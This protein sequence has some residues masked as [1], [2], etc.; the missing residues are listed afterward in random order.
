MRALV[1]V[2][3]AALGIVFPAVSQFKRIDA[4]PIVLTEPMGTV[5]M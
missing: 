4:T 5:G 1:K 3:V 2:T